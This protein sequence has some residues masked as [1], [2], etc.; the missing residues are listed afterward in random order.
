MT[1]RALITLF[2]LALLVAPLARAEDAVKKESKGPAAL[3]PGSVQTKGAATTKPVAPPPSGAEVGQAV[4]AMASS[5]GRALALHTDISA[6]AAKLK[7]AKTARTKSNGEMKKKLRAVKA[8]QGKV[9]RASKK[10]GSDAAALVE[11][12]RAD[13]ESA[14]AESKTFEVETQTIATTED[15]LTVLVRTAEGAAE[16]C[17]KYEATI[18]AA[19]LAAK[20][21][22]TEAKKHAAKA[23]LIGGVRPGKA[24][25]SDRAKH[26]KDIEAVKLETE[27]ARAAF[28]AMKGEAAKQPPPGATDPADG[29]KAPNAAKPVK[30]P[31]AANQGKKGDAP[32]QMKKP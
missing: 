25:L 12:A 5:C 29:K 8:S 32:G 13:Y 1:V 23:R 21:A 2:A 11:T 22:V 19:A 9:T 30:D 3:K 10:P 18:R 17:T 24:L 20:K 4:D 26:A 31:A 6:L 14:L 7:A 28:E 16:A 15:Q 27:R